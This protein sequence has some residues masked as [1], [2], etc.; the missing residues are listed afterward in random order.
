MREPAFWWRPAGLA[1]ALLV[2]AGCAL[3]R[4]SRRAGMAR[5]G[6][7]GRRAGDLRRQSRRSAAPA[8]RRPRSRWRRC[9]H[10]AG[11]RP[12]LLTRGYGGALAGPVRVDPARIARPMS[13]TSRCCWRA[14][15]DHRGARPRRRRRPPRAAGASVDRDGRRLPEPVARQGP[16]ASGGRRR[17]G[18]GNGRVFPAGPL[19]APLAAQLRSRPC[20]CWWS[21]RAAQATRSPRHA[22]AR[23]MPVFH[24]RL[25]PDAAAARG[26]RR[27]GRCWRSPASAIRRSSSRRWRGRHR[28]RG[29]RRLSRPPPLSRAPRR[30][31]LIARAE[32]DGLVLVTTEKDLA[33][34]AGAGR[35]SRRWPRV[36]ERCR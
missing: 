36:A 35:R 19:R 16:L 17:R 33:R 14:R 24:G 27:G 13:A 34:L 28:R 30:A 10:A 32:R 22:R 9:S 26:A 15:A 2:A 6:P 31:T 5:A 11:R 7:R 25:E 29:A 1:A 3:W 21:A 23:G 18:I 4:A 12:F 20:A 8:R